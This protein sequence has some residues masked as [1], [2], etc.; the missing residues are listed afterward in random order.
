LPTETINVIHVR[1]HDELRELFGDFDNNLRLIKDRLKVKVYAKG[2]DVIV[3]GDEQAARSAISLIKNMLGV[4]RN[5]G[6]LEHEYIEYLIEEEN[7]ADSRDAAPYLVN[8]KPKTPGQETYVQAIEDNDIT[9]CYG[10]AGTGK[11]YLAVAMAVSYYKRRLVDRIVLTRPAVEAGESLGF[12]PGTVAEK[13]NPYLIPLFDALND[14][15]KFEKV[16]KLIERGVVEVAPLAFMRGRS[17][18]NSFIILDEAQN[19][20]YSQMKMFLTRMG[21]LSKVVVTGDITQIDLASGDKSGFII[22]MEI[23][24]PI[25][26]GI[27]VVHLTERDVVRHPAVQKIITAY[28]KYEA[29]RSNSH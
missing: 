1:D 20:T 25:K 19:T 11:T 14:L 2:L 13:V 8:S 22:A 23:L 5:K 10:P 9:L 24:K 12:L 6:V 18:N 17:L 27:C 26:P 4:I 16:K 15:L 21:R 7:L 3:S 28:D 29:K